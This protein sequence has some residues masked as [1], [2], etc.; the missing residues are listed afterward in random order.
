M[1]RELFHGAERNGHTPPTAWFDSHSLAE[2]ITERC[3]R[4]PGLQVSRAALRKAYR[5]WCDGVG[6]KWPVS[7][8]KLC[9]GVRQRGARDME[10][11]EHGRTVRGFTGIGLRE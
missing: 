8:K 5:D 11:T 9:E 6:D 1:R 4:A 7:S 10:F 2:F 3:I